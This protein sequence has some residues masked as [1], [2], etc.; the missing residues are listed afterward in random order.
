[1]ALVEIILRQVEAQRQRA[2][3][4]LR[5]RHAL[6]DMRGEEFAE[7]RTALPDRAI[8][9]CRPP[10]FSPFT[11]P[12]MQLARQDEGLFL[13]GVLV[14]IGVG[15]HAADRH[16]ALPRRMIALVELR[17]VGARLLEEHQTPGMRNIELGLADAVIGE[18]E[19]AGIDAGLA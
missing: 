17:L 8:G 3:Q 15:I 4:P 2:A 10:E 11:S 5:D 14:G 6:G 12:G 7:A 18:I 1:M 13:I 16:P 9:R 19:E